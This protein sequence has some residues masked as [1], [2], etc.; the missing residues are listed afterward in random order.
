VFMVSSSCNG[1][2]AIRSVSS[3]QLA[4]AF[5]L[6]PDR[7]RSSARGTR[8]CTRQAG[9]GSEPRRPRRDS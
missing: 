9:V 7:W 8:W 5:V 4:V 1:D 2:T 3:S 6:Q